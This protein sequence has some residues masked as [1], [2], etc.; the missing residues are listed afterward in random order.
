[1]YEISGLCVNGT[2]CEKQ[3]TVCQ[4][5][6]PRRDQ[7]GNEKIIGAVSVLDLT[8]YGTALVRL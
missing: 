4:Y 3:Y 1:M 6:I 8:K 5:V 7:L 2:E